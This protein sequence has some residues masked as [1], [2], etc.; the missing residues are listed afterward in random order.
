C[1]KSSGVAGCMKRFIGSLL[2][3]LTLSGSAAVARA[4]VA[5]ATLLGEI[6]DQSAAV[7]PGVTVTARNTAT[8][9]TRTAVTGAQGAYRIDE[10][11]PGNYTVIA[12]KPG[13]RE[14]TAEGV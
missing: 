6:R 5:S 4:Q 3:I 11:L 2:L 10:L 1:R 12:G 13:F 9:F 7:A 8:G 14:V